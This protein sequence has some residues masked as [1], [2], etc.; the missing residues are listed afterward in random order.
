MQ[1]LLKE[2][3]NRN[4]IKLNS[5]ID[6]TPPAKWGVRFSYKDRNYEFFVV[7]E[8]D[9]N[10]EVRIYPERGLACL[11]SRLKDKI[12]SYEDIHNLIDKADNVTVHVIG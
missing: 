7:E 11:A 1:D 5:Q 9:K 12:H 2:L 10:P 4:E 8:N 3:E 6:V